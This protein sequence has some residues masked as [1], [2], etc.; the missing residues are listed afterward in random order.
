[1]KKRLPPFKGEPDEPSSWADAARQAGRAEKD[2]LVSVLDIGTNKVACLVRGSIRWKRT[3]R[4]A[5]HA[6]GANPRHRPPAFAR[7][8][9]RRDQR[10]ELAEEPSARP[11]TRPSAWPRSSEVEHRQYLGRPPFLG[12]ARRARRYARASRSAT[13]TCASPCRAPAPMR[14]A[15]AGAVVHALPTSFALDGQRRSRSAGMVG[16]PSASA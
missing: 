8:E 2:R 7:A 1:M 15:R 3:P 5:A 6:Y 10:L 12:G 9:G 11:C 16:R 13:G 14:R 4:C